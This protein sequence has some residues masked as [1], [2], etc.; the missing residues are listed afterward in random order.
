MNAPTRSPLPTRQGDLQSAPTSAALPASAD[1]ERPHAVLLYHYFHP[2]DVVSARLYSDLAEGLVWRGWDVTAVP[3]QRECRNSEA[4]HPLAETW[5][6]VRVRRVWRPAFRQSANRGRAINAAWMLAAWAGAAAT[7]PPRRRE[8]V[9]VGT[10]P[11]FGVLAALPWKAVRRR[12]GVVHWCHDLYPEAAIAEGMVRASSPAIRVLRR[13]LAAAYRRCDVVADLGPCM[14]GL[15]ASYG[16]GA[17]VA[18]LTPWA[19]VEPPTPVE[20]DPATRRELFGNSTIGLLY[21]G[22]FGRAHCYDDFLK[23]ARAM[24]GDPVRLCFA[25]R[26]N[27]ADELRAA[28][29]TE[30]TNVSFA[31]FA[32]EAELE[33]RLG[34]CDLHLV[35]LRP[36]W[37]GAVVPSKFFGALAAGRGV[38]FAGSP[39]S[40]IARWVAEYQVGWVLTPATLP[41][42]AAEL[43]RLAADP[44]ALF[45]LRARCHAVYHEHFSKSCQLDRWDA[46]LRAVI[47]RQ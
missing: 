42:V 9:V 21:S 43:R 22:S 7:L 13:V 46:V 5:Q 32:P 24:R 40:A 41:G 12:T 30:D 44:T 10:D 2:D 17:H 14:R 20:P 3:C 11:V 27:R 18:T 4:V 23:L 16:T 38:V 29:T 1:E 31:G 34:A 19:L 47:P 28:V 6:G 37:T 25:G 33:R 45:A 15:L 35:S 39:D 8:V 36:E 26:G